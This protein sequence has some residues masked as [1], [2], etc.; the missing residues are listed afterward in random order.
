LAVGVGEIQG[1]MVVK[2]VALEVLLGAG[3]WQIINVQ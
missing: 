3:P 1:Q 2:V